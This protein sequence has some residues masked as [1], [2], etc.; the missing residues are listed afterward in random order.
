M[1]TY[2]VSTFNGFLTQAEQQQA[3]DEWN[4]YM[5]GAGRLTRAAWDGMN[6]AQ[7]AAAYRGW[8]PGMATIWV[9]RGGH[10]IMSG[11]AE[12]RKYDA[13]REKWGKIAAQRAE[14]DRRAAG[15]T[16][17]TTTTTTG[18]QTL[19]M[20][21]PDGS[22]GGPA[23]YAYGKW[24]SGDGYTKTDPDYD[25]LYR[26]NSDG[27]VGGD[28]AIYTS[29]ETPIRPNGGAASPDYGGCTTEFNK[30][31]NVW[32]SRA[33]AGIASIVV[34]FPEVGQYDLKVIRHTELPPDRQTLDRA[35]LGRLISR[36]EIIDQ[37]KYAILNL[38]HVHSLTEVQFEASEQIQGN[39]QEM[40]AMVTSLLRGFTTGNAGVPIWTPLTETRNPARIVMDILTG[41]SIQNHKDFPSHL[42]FDGGWVS[43]AQID[44]VSF[45]NFMVH[46]NEEVEYFTTAGSMAKEKR[47]R[48]AIDIILASDAPIIETCQSILAMC[49]AQLIIN[50]KGKIAIMR[51]E[52]KDL[53]KPRQLFTPANSWGFTGR[54]DFPQIPDGFDVSYVEPSLGYQPTTVSVYRPGFTEKNASFMEEL[55]TF[56]VTN[57][58]QAALYGKYMLAQAVIRQE[59]FTLNVDVESLVCIRGD[60]VEVQHDVPLTGGI[61]A[62]VTDVRAAV[63]NLIRLYLDQ[64]FNPFPTTGLG[65]GMTWRNSAGVIRHYDIANQHDLG[66]NTVTFFLKA[67]DPSPQ[68]GDLVVIGAKKAGYEIEK[69][70]TDYYLISKIIPQQDLTAQL[71]LVRYDSR[72]YKTD[73]GYFPIWDPSFG[74]NPTTGTSLYVRTITGTA[75]LTFSNRQPISTSTLT[76]D[77]Q[78]QND[79]DTIGG[80]RI[81]FHQNGREPIQLAQLSGTALTWTHEYAENDPRFIGGGTYKVVPISSLGWE[82]NGKEVYVP[83]LRDREGPHA[84]KLLAEFT[85]TL[86]TRLSWTPD[87]TDGDIDHWEL[88]QQQTD[89]SW[90]FLARADWDQKVYELDS[91]DHTKYKIIPFDTSSNE[92]AAAIDEPKEKTPVPPNNFNIH[93]VGNSATLTWDLENDPFVNH[94]HLLWNPDSTVV[95]PTAAGTVDLG[96]TDKLTSTMAVAPRDGVYFI[97]ATNVFNK[98]STTA[99]VTTFTQSVKTLP[100]NIQQKLEFRNRYPFDV[101]TLQWGL[102]GRALD[103]RE[104]VVYFTDAQGEKH[105]LGTTTE[106]KFEWAVDVINQPDL[107]NGTF[108]VVPLNQNGQKGPAGT[109]NYASLTDSTPPVAPEGFFANIIDKQIE[110]NWFLSIS[111]DIDYYVVRY[112]PELTNPLWEHG[113]TILEVDHETDNAV[114]PARTG[115]YMLAVY[116]TS[117][118]RST[119]VTQRTQLSELPDLNVVTKIEEATTGWPGVRN[120]FDITARGLELSAPFRPGSALD[121]PYAEGTYIFNTIY[122]MGQVFEARIVDKLIRFGESATAGNED[123]FDAWIEYRVSDRTTVIADWPTLDDPIADPIA[124]T[125]SGAYTPWR[126]AYVSDFTGRFVQLRLVVRAYHA[127][128]KVIVTGGQIEIDMPDRVFALHD[129]AIPVAGKTI[130]ITPPMREIKAI[131]VTIDGN[132][133]HAFSIIDPARKRPDGFHLELQDVAATGASGG[134]HGSHSVK[135]QVDIMVLGYGTVR[136][137]SI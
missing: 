4:N 5:S 111:K 24:A 91:F 119:I 33:D 118:N 86:G 67:G 127:D 136:P 80:I 104:Y 126:R 39:V 96:Q 79:R 25:K 15:W 14:A 30:P 112:T 122:D 32:G 22:T 50:E 44:F 60:L 35:T 135:G 132:D 2:I 131:S 125:A 61:A 109:A 69:T 45:T 55:T 110:L 116:D 77:T 130:N 1:A 128:T 78:P 13:I 18:Q 87:A 106:R 68:P 56:G 62:R 76:W 40:S 34:P 51:D 103:V 75:G 100:P 107:T 53:T 70:V 98:E 63:G 129:I 20:V 65:L 105:L 7:K 41:F 74:K 3:T 115:T 64:D 19:I 21:A 43:D 123:D 27:N 134:S 85:P 49:R 8:Q 37:D 12:N 54:K 102:Q 93:I 29:T 48:Y 83:Q 88:Y 66:T 52:V 72:V 36:G 10:R 99:T 71:E 42:K 137:T 92:G 57:R 9:T 97:S 133:V 31:F 47:P 113:S 114:I 84:P 23:G 59:I 28:P 117:G 124:G 94:Y 26:G 121:K 16:Y 38:Q 81:S 46:C 108:S 6:D 11:S 17:K 90:K 95:D 82:G 101:I 120:G 73:W 89:G 58:D